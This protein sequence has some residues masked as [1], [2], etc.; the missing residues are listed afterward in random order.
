MAKSTRPS[1]SQAPLAQRMRPQS[2]DAVI[3]QTHLLAEGAPLR[4]CSQSFQ[5][6]SNESK[7][8]KLKAR[9]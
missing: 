2:L 7:I 8:G 6:Q 4:T 3:G 5:Q 9:I 1:S